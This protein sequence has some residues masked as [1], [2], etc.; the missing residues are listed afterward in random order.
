MLSW[1]KYVQLHTFNHLQRIHF[2]T[3]QAEVTYLSLVR[4]LQGSQAWHQPDP[5]AVSSPHDL[6]S[7]QHPLNRLHTL[8]TDEVTVHNYLLKKKRGGNQPL[9]IQLK[10]TGF[11]TK[12]DTVLIFKIESDNYNKNFMDVDLLPDPDSIKTGTMGLPPE[13]MFTGFDLAGRDTGTVPTSTASTSCSSTFVLEY[14][15]RS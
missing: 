14:H 6:P 11:Q 10:N 2:P 15:L 3:Q 8:P 12:Q 5:L 7:V 1:F 4:V 9:L 13:G